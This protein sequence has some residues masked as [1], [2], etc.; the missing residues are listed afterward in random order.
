MQIP[1]F[2]K[3]VVKICLTKGRISNFAISPIFIKCWKNKQK[4]G[5]NDTAF[6]D[7]T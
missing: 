4:E 3:E 5:K 1:K 6:V 2:K 7:E